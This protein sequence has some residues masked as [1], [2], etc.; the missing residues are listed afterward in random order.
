M[1]IEESHNVTFN[2]NPLPSKTSPLVDDDLDEEKSIK[3]LEKKKL[4]NNIKDE[5]L[6]IDEI[7]NIKESRNHPLE[8][9][10]GNLNQRTFR[11]QAQNQSNFFRFIST[12]EPMNVIETLTDESWLIAMQEELNQ[13]IAND[14]WEL[15]PQPKNMT[16]IGTKLVFRN[17]LDENVVISRNKA[18]ILLAYACALD[19]K[20][21]QM[22]VKNA[23]LN[24]FISEEFK[25]SMMGELN[26][27]LGLQIK[28]MEDGIFF[29]Q[30]KYIKE[31][32]EKFGLEDSKPMKTPTFSNTKLTK[33]EECESV[34]STKYR[35]MIG[36]LLY[37]TAS[38]PDIMFSVCLCARFQ[39]APKT[40]HLE[41]VK[42]IFRYIKGT[43][44]LGLWYPKGTSI[45][46]VV[47][48]DSDHARDY[49]DRKS[50][51]GIGGIDGLDGTKRGY[52]RL[53]HGEIFCL[54]K[55][56]DALEKKSIMGEPLSPDHVFDFPMD[57]SEP[58]PAYDFFVPGPLPGYVGNPNNNNGWIE[59]DVPLLGELVAEADEP[60]DLAMLFSDEDF[61][62]DDSEGFE[63]AKEV[64]EVNE[65]WLMAPVTPPPMLVVPP[66]STYEVGGPSTAATE[67]QSFPL[68]APGLPVPPSMIKDL[69]TRMGNLEYGHGHLVKKVIQ[70]MASP[71]V[72]AVGRLE[73][74][75][76][77]VEQGQRTATQRDE[78]ISGLSQQVQALQAVVQ[79]RD[80]QI[81][82]L[83]TMVSKMSSRES[84][85]MQCIL[86]MDRRL[87]DLERR[88]PGPQ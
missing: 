64:W 12:I 73:Q 63:D 66:P 20:L 16:I 51:S 52:Q 39:E 3:F 23:F 34:D 15:V 55:Q 36:S 56:K 69:C 6:E 19:F 87:A 68:P 71:M 11:S 28:Q 38:R 49:G 67:G 81:Q 7:V 41:M 57:E 22:D 65:E 35:G 77:Q 60:M 29:N 48:A 32:L 46:I 78:V 5:T 74:V 18:R 27:F 17:K 85:L 88:P 10:I 80:M 40:S 72:Q 47:Y 54:F 82:Q 79:Q 43:T 75:G 13:F 25:M 53:C 58:R 24:G 84:T 21:F 61:G 44:H 42:R 30:S 70:V 76:A 37:L 14:V 45:E 86:G 2:E 83:Q 59:A 4:E 33:D 26:F 50:T 62:D 9:V 31:M 8:N 1:K